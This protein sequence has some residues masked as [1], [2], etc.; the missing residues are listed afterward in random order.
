MASA[1]E[2]N[3]KSASE[4]GWSP[5]DFG[6]PPKKFGDDL[7]EAVK[8]FQAEWDL[9][10]DGYCGPNTVRRLDML[11]DY[12]GDEPTTPPRGS[13]Y[14]VVGGKKLNI[15]WPNVVTFDEEGGYSLTKGFSKKNRAGKGAVIH[16]PVTYEPSQTIKVLNKRGVGTHFEIGPAMGLGGDVT[17]YQYCDVKHRAYH[18]K[19]ANNFVGIDV[20]TPVYAKPSV[21]QKLIDLG[22]SPRPV[23]DN[24][25][26]NG[27][28]PGPIL[29]YHENQIRALIALLAALNE[30]AGVVLD[31]P[32]HTGNWRNVRSLHRKADVIPGVYHHAEVDYPVDGK[33]QG[34][35]D[36]AGICL[37]QVTDLAKHLLES[38][39]E[40]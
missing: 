28:K 24:I 39:G 5:A 20:S 25:K 2:Y 15:D 11:A 9:A 12:S 21:I 8:L 32:A 36:T 40:V 33:R 37:K 6:L 30:H 17:I 10:V 16:W 34:K 27:W 19:T 1:S 18:S 38:R 4:H 3:K 35:W 29:G 22:H 7:T 13:D 14:I 31:A 23:I 26:I